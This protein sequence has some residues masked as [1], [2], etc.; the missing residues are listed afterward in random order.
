MYS[1]CRYGIC[2]LALSVTAGEIGDP[3]ALLARARNK[4]AEVLRHLP[5]Y[6]CVQT[7]ERMTRRGPSKRYELIDVVRLEVALVNGRE[8]FAWPGSGNFEDTEISEMVTGGAIGNGNF[9]VHANAI[10][11]SAAPQFVFK[12][13]E[14]DI[15]QMSLRWD[16]IV[17]RERSGYMIRTAA[18]DGKHEAVVGYH[19]SIWVDPVS[20]DILRFD[21]HADDIPRRLELLSAQDSVRYLR[22][23]IGSR[24]FLLPWSSDLA[25]TDLNGSESRNRTRFSSCRE[26]AGESVITFDDPAGEDRP[27]PLRSLEVPAGLPLELRLAT[28]ITDVNSAVGDPITATLN[29]PVKLGTDLVAPKGAVAHGRITFLRKQTFSRSSG[30]IIGLDFFEISWPNTLAKVHARLEDM[31]SAV[32]RPNTPSAFGLPNSRAHATALASVNIPG[33]VL[34]VQG[35]TLKLDRGLLM[36]WRTTAPPSEKK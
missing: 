24:E 25:M 32:Y 10:F 28:V 4:M 17:R 14:Q 26:Y 11:R 31:A 2:L 34:V 33:S 5:N 27:A 19:G 15:N 21:V 36:Y 23:R 8:L 16:Y 18:S 20:L 6:T 7:I 3:A 30:F 9:A 29:K 13:E 1:P 12:G 35:Y 22:T